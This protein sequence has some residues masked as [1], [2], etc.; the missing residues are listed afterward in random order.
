[1]SRKRAIENVAIELLL[2]K[3]VS[4]SINEIIQEAGI[5]KGGFYH[6]FNSKHQLLK[7]S[8]E[9]YFQHQWKLI[10][11]IAQSQKSYIQ[12]IEDLIDAL[13]DPYKKASQ[14]SEPGKQKNYLSLVNEYIKI[15][16]LANRY[17]Q[18]HNAVRD[19]IAKVLHDNRN[20]IKIPDRQNVSEIS[21]QIIYLS[22]GILFYSLLSD[23]G[24][25][26]H[27][28]KQEVRNYLKII[29]GKE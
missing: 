4:A 9:K 17:Y 29:T 13:F 11:E 1:M 3:G 26:L 8:I 15:P 27:R 28:S 16:E 19:A 25:V 10:D 5:S 24:D 21:N 22:E 6:Y 2:E 7:E 20:N 14:Q 23:V 18:F 12:K